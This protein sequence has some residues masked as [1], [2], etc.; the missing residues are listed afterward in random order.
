M[1]SGKMYCHPVLEEDPW[2][3]ISVELSDTIILLHG[4][5]CGW[6][7]SGVPL[8]RVWSDDD[9]MTVAVMTL[10]CDTGNLQ[11]RSHFYFQEKIITGGRL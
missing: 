10:T 4:V 9:A 7:G 1:F 2:T 11:R 8:V 5:Q 6:L 3:S